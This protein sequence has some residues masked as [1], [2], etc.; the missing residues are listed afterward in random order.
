MFSFRLAELLRATLFKANNFTSF[1]LQLC[2]YGYNSDSL[3]ILDSFPEGGSISH[4]YTLD[5]DDD[6]D[7]ESLTFFY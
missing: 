3:E 4:D 6:L 5:E 7:M 2:G 1:T